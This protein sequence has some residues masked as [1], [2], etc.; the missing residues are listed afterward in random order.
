ML[1]KNPHCLSCSCS[2]KGCHHKCHYYKRTKL[3]TQTNRQK[4]E[5][6]TSYYVQGKLRSCSFQYLFSET[7]MICLC[8]SCNHLSFHGDNNHC[9][10]LS[11]LIFGF[12][13]CI[14]VTLISNSPLKMASPGSAFLSIFLIYSQ[15]Y[16]NHSPK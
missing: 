4:Y 11:P 9:S 10:K 3:C 8:T 15:I 1:F 7:A 13:F 2:L 12:V 16:H 5:M 14:G 6:K